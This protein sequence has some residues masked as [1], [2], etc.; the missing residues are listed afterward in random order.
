[1]N[2]KIPTNPHALKITQQ[3]RGRTGWVY[4]LSAGEHRLTVSTFPR[5]NANEP[6]EWRVEARASRSDEA[7][8][9]SEWA[10]TK[11]EAL[12]KVGVAWVA[13]AEAD[14]L[15]AFDFD[16]VSKLLETVRGV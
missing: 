7:I 13:R 11:A 12:Q 9:V 5:E 15:P 16:A 1:M 3:A 8:V 2:E 14:D 10:P 4:D 6:G